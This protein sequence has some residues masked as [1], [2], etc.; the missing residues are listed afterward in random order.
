MARASARELAE[1]NRLL[2]TVVERG[3][4]LEEGIELIAA[5]TPSP[6]F[7]RALREVISSLREG[8]SASDA[9]AR[10]ADIFGSEYAAQVEVGVRTGHLP[11]ML[12]LAETHH[13]LQAR[14]SRQAVRLGIYVGV[15]TAL[16]VAGLALFI[17]LAAFL[18]KLYLAYGMMELP[19]PTS[20]VLWIV[21]HLWTIIPVFVVSVGLGW[22]AIQLL[23]RTRLGAGMEY[24]I[25]VWG[26]YRRRR[27]L[28]VFCTAMSLRLSAGGPLPDCLASAGDAV[29]NGYFRAIVRQV[30]E[31]IEDGE[32]LSTALFYQRFVPRTLSWGISLGEARGDVPEAFQAFSRTYGAEMSRDFQVVMLLMT[33]LAILLLGN[34]A[35][36]AAL[37]VSMPIMDI[38]A[39]MSG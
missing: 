35:M 27:D 1:F 15:G 39:A 36:F 25:P 26:A 33:P 21:A 31:R 12:R 29:R 14:L 6:A 19:P 3:L 16:C 30:R 23:R 10:R 38:Q 28:S 20:L 34:I 13:E 2:A 7:R 8:A 32:S 9:F 17:P 18:G 22:R 5:E 11:S 4:P 24:G 37:S